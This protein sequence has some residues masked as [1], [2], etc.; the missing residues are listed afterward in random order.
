M[1]SKTWKRILPEVLPSSGMLVSHSTTKSFFFLC[2][3]LHSSQSYKHIPERN[4]CRHHH[5]LPTSLGKEV[6]I[7]KEK[8]QTSHTH[9]HADDRQQQR[10]NPCVPGRYTGCTSA[11]Q[12]MPKTTCLPCMPQ[13]H[14]HT[15]SNGLP[16][17]SRLFCKVKIVAFLVVMYKM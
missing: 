9:S 7:V 3:A 14:Q 6:S 2:L 11:P 13:L 10:Q 4:F 12:L 17:V 15:D 8:G 1:K 5:S 16:H